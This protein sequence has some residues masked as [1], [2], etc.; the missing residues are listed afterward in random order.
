M[1]KQRAIANAITAI[2]GRFLEEAERY[3][4]AS[5]KRILSRP[6]LSMAACLLLV[7]GLT[8]LWPRPLKIQVNGENVLKDAVSVSQ[9]AEPMALRAVRT[10][11]VPLTLEPGRGGMVTVDA[12]GNSALEQNGEETKSLTLA[13][14]TAVTW[15]L[16]PD[17][18]QEFYLTVT[19]GQTEYLLRA[20]LEES[21]SVTLRR[22]Q[23]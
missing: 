10:V 8:F 11:S 19:Q 21:G 15:L 7:A 14:K 4:A 23:P 16:Y 1:D 9:E 6:M 3:A 22:V 13:Q 12:D 2:D 17:D 18:T 20:L 5:K